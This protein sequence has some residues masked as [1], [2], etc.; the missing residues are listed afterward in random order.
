M[1]FATPVT[2]IMIFLYQMDRIELVLHFAG[3]SW[4]KLIN[5]FIYK[6]YSLIVVP[7]HGL[8]Y[9]WHKSKDNVI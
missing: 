9:A 3:C 2:Q 6:T 5:A 4:N 7:M 1:L 8:V